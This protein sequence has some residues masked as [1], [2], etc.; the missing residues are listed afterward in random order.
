MATRKKREKGKTEEKN[1][2]QRVREREMKEVKKEREIVG[3]PIQC[4]VCSC[5]YTCHSFSS[6]PYVSR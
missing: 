4:I 6:F 3:A 5:S 2:K 1:E